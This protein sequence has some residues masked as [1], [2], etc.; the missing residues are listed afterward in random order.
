MLHAISVPSEGE[1]DTDA[2][3]LTMFGVPPRREVAFNIYHDESGT[4][5]PSGGERWLLHG[6]LFVP[7]A[8]QAQFFDQLQEVRVDSG[9]YHEVHFRTLGKSTTG[10][11]GR[12]CAS[13][14]DLCAAQFSTRCYY[15]CLAVDTDST[16]F[17]PDRFGE[18]H[19]AYNYFARTA[20]VGGIAWCLGDY[21][22]V[23]L[24]LHSDCKARL[25]GDNFEEYIPREVAGAIEEKRR[26]RPGA[27]PHIR[28]LAERV[29]LVDSDP[30]SV[31]NSLRQECELTQLV[32]LVTS[33]IMQA[34]TAQSGR[35]GKLA[36]AE[37]I[38]AWVA[39]TRKPPWLQREELHRRFSVSCFP[40]PDGGYYKAAL[41]VTSRHQMRLFEESG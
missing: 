20:I 28:L 23:A 10:P 22:V 17:M 13:W 21:P 33:G 38:A 3:Q 9:Y 4:Y 41:S 39:D 1:V 32:D 35:E 12:C 34:L 14:L 5:T 31:H 7:I 30:M 37:L 27:Y 26:G 8:S 36:L 6:V 19:Q 18:P 15:H 11:K 40:G 24:K 25:E 16:A 2:E 29:V